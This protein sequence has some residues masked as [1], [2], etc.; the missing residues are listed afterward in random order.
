MEGRVVLLNGDRIAVRLPDSS[1]SVFRLLA[2][3]GI[4]P[5]I[6]DSF[7]GTLSSNG[8]QLL[9]HCRSQQWV[10]VKIKLAS[11]RVAA[12][13]KRFLQKANPAAR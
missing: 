6:G 12:R 4:E 10:D 8:A 2:D 13:T 9:L 11:T 1:Y 7:L 5:E 3:S